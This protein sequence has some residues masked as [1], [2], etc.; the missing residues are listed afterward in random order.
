MS[1]ICHK[2]GILAP[3]SSVF[4]S[5]YHPEGL[6]KWWASDAHGNAEA[7]G[8]LTLCFPGYPDH[9]WEVAELQPSESVVLKFLSGPDG[10]NGSILRFAMQQDD[11][12]VWLTLYHELPHD[13]PEEA[14]QYFMTKWPMYLI[15]LKSY[16]ETGQG[17]PFPNDIK[18]Q[19]DG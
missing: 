3:I 16:L 13:A 4:S 17:M 11:K 14:T 19:L 5:T 15:S 10:W 6:S 9:E 8:T 18:I 2:V 1:I 12:Q 7:G